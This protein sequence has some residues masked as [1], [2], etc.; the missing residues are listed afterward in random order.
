MLI[1]YYWIKINLFQRIK[2]K[3]NHIDWL[4]FIKK[5]LS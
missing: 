5:F 2:C 4:L 3:K 1:L